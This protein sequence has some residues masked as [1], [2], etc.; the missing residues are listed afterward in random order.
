LS[1][2]ISEFLNKHSLIELNIGSGKVY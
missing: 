1:D 2:N